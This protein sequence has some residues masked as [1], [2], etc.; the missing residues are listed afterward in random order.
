LARKNYNW[1]HL[2][3][4]DEQIQEK[5][6]GKGFRHPKTRKRNRKPSRSSQ[7]EKEPKR[8]L[9]GM[10]KQAQVISHPG[11]GYLRQMKQKTG[12]KEDKY[13]RARLG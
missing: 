8:K 11:R 6:T 4:Y 10:P 12:S 1:N 5:L 7:L 3:E 9:Y 13:E 2:I